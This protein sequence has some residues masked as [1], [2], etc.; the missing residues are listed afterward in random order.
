MIKAKYKILKPTV[1]WSCSWV[2]FSLILALPVTASTKQ[3]HD[4]TPLELSGY[5]L[6]ESYQVEDDQP[7]DFES[8]ILKQLLYRVR[9][10]SPKSR[11]RYSQF[12]Q[13]TT[14][15]E[16]ISRTEDFR[17]WTFS[18][19]AR[20]TKIEK[21]AFKQGSPDDEIKG[22]YVCHCEATSDSKD[23]STTPPQKLIVLSRT[24]PMALPINTEINQPIRISGFLYARILD[25][26]GAR[27]AFITDRIQ[28]Y[29]PRRIKQNLD[30]PDQT[31]ETRI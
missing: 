24:V 16:I 20:L 28:W 14:W 19:P 27:L 3:D 15:R 30:P 29:P 26:S 22:V 31:L 4:E 6:S 13:N 8:P 21:H 10:T 25:P 18:R 5:S 1:V 9:H 11:A 23:D 2:T 7:A 17:F 12:S